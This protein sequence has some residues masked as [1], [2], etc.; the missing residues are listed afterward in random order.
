MEESLRR[1]RYV[2]HDGHDAT[3]VQPCNLCDD[4]GWLDF[5]SQF[6]CIFFS[7]IGLLH[8]VHFFVRLSP[9]SGTAMWIMTKSYLLIAF[10]QMIKSWT[11]THNC[12][13]ESL[14]GNHVVY[15][16]LAIVSEVHYTFLFCC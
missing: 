3:P 4:D 10:G 11:R 16:L 15:C 5:K 6:P 2:L 7:R 14:P 1:Y 9:Y 13:M 8:V 12:R